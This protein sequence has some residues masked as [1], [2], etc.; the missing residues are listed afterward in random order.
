M[1]D[2]K[3]IKVIG[4]FVIAT[5]DN[6]VEIANPEILVIKKTEDKGK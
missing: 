4:K 5:D 3:R 6:K 1:A 2:V